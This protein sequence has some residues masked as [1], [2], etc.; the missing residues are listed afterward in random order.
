MFAMNF[1]ELGKPM[2][3]GWLKGRKKKKNKK[4][5]EQNKDEGDNFIESLEL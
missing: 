5:N 1:V 2:L 3:M 4:S